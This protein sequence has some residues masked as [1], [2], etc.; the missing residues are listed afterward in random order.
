MSDFDFP[1]S[2]SL[3]LFRFFRSF[4]FR[5]PFVALLPFLFVFF[6]SPSSYLF[7]AFSVFCFLFGCFLCSF[8]PLSD[9]YNL[10]LP[11]LS[12]SL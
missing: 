7:L 9:F 12:F 1:P 10:I 3:Y 5:F 2:V 6:V 11:P 8:F 4:Y